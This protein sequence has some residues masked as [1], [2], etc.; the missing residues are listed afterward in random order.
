MHIPLL[1]VVVENKTMT[2]VETIGLILQ[3]L[4]TVGMKDILGIQYKGV[5]KQQLLSIGIISNC[6]FMKVFP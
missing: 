6:H 5:D 2:F 3:I 1:S 4:Q